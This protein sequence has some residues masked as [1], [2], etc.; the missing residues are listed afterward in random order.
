MDEH[1]MISGHYHELLENDPHGYETPHGSSIDDKFHGWMQRARN[2]HKV[3]KKIC[4][5]CFCVKNQYIYKLF[6]LHIPVFIDDGVTRKA[7]IFYRKYIC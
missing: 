2:Y 5:P 4:S 6:A 1:K 3:K 7:Y